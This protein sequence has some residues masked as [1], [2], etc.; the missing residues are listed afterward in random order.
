MD[1]PYFKTVS[2]SFLTSAMPHLGHL[3]SAFVLV[4]SGCIGQVKVVLCAVSALISA[5]EEVGCEVVCPLLW[6]APHDHKPITKHKIATNRFFILINFE[7]R[8]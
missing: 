3:S 1:L 6:S 8:F 5:A 2:H 7:N 4:T